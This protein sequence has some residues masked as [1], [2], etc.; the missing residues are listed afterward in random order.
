MIRE[1]AGQMVATTE[2]SQVQLLERKSAPQT[3]NDLGVINEEE[4]EAKQEESNMDDKLVDVTNESTNTEV[5]VDADAT[6]D[7]SLDIKTKQEDEQLSSNCSP[8]EVSSEVRVQDISDKNALE[9]ETPKEK[10]VNEGEEFMGIEVNQV[11]TVGTDDSTLLS[12]VV[13]E[14]DN[15]TSSSSTEDE[16]DT[17]DVLTNLEGFSPLVG[18]KFKK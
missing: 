11:E 8:Q 7:S 9:S 5:N 16:V 3:G 17:S 4:K 2:G 15:S 14:P 1:A 13:P 10:D 18:M 6:E 12:A